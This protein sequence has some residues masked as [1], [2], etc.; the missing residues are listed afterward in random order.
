MQP[1]IR[2]S[3]PAWNY[4][5][6]ST[7]PAGRWDIFKAVLIIIMIIRTAV[8]ELNNNVPWCKDLIASGV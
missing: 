8:M 6:I 1:P 3:K 5:S 2:A 4:F 7:K